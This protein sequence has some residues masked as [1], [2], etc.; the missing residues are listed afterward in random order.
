M[1]VEEDSFCW[2]NY[3]TPRKVISRLFTLLK[4]VFNSF[5]LIVTEVTSEKS[6]ETENITGMISS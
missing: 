2:S 4:L 5:V 6:F 3:V 1:K